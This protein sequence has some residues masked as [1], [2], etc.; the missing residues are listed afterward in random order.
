VSQF[1]DEVHCADYVL[2]KITSGPA[3]EDFLDLVHSAGTDK[4]T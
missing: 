2:G 1:P 3:A 4:I